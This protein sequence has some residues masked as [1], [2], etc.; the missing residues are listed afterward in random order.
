MKN[1]SYVLIGI[2]LLVIFS[3]GCISDRSEERDN[4]TEDI[5]KTCIENGYDNVFTSF[6]AFILVP[7]VA[8]CYK[9]D[10]DV[11]VDIARVYGSE[12]DGYKIFPEESCK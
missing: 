1:S 8:C 10:G 4:V 6:S 9:L 11:V 5:N 7:N 12:T 3:S 2:L